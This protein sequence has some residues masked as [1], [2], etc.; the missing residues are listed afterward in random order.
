MIVKIRNGKLTLPKDLQK[1][2]GTEAV[3]LF[4]HDG[5]YIKPL[6]TPSLAALQPKLKKAGTQLT[7][8]GV[9]AAVTSARRRTYAGRS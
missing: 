9:A 5:L 4:A 7:E 2:W 1:A 8:Q 6:T 3:M